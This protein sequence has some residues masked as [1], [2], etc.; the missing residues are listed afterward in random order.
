MQGGPCLA[1][2]DWVPLIGA[3]FAGLSVLMGAFLAH[4]RISADRQQLLM[5]VQAV[6][7]RERVQRKEEQLALALRKVVNGDAHK[8]EH[9]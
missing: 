9:Q 6:A 7:E 4:R 3:V 2:V 8:S 5:H 1:S